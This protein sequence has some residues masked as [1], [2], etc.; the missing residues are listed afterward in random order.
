[1]HQRRLART[2]FAGQRVDLSA[3][4][5]QLGATQGLNRSERLVH[6]RHAEDDLGHDTPPSITSTYPGAARCAAGI[7]RVGAQRP[8]MYSL[9]SKDAAFAL[10][11]TAKPLSIEGTCIGL[12]PETL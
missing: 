11:M 9:R 4:Q 7:M 8:F 5:F 6:I 1:M 2:V 12:K 10:V 3:A